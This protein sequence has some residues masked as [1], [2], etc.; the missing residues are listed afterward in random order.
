MVLARLAIVNSVA[1]TLVHPGERT[2]LPHCQLDEPGRDAWVRD[3]EGAGIDLL[4]NNRKN[5]GTPSDRIAPRSIGV[6]G[7]KSTENAGAMQEIVHQSIHDDKAGTD[8][9]PALATRSDQQ[10]R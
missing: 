10:Q 6:I 4:G 1:I 7:R 8:I 5:F 3:A 2:V 9:D